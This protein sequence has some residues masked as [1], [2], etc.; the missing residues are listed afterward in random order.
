[1]KRILLLGAGKIGQTIRLFLDQL[2]DI[3]LVI[4]DLQQLPPPDCE[5]IKLESN[6][7]LA[8]LLSRKHIDAVIN[9]GPFYLSTK[10][11]IAAFSA[12]C[13]YFDLTE[14]IKASQHIKSLAEKAPAGQLFA[15][16]CGLA[17]GFISILCSHICSQF[18]TL[19]TVRL[20]VGAL[21]QYP[22]N[23]M[24]YNLTWSTDGLVNEY[25]NP[26]EVIE[27]GKLIHVPALDN[28]EEFS[29]E[30]IRYEAFNTSG[31]LGSLPQSLLNKVNQ[32]N[33]KTIRYPG[34]RDLMKFLLKDLKFEQQQRQKELVQLLDE[35]IPMTTQD[36]VL[37]MV[38]V[39]G[40]K[41]LANGELRYEKL[42]DVR[43][44]LHRT[45]Q[46]QD[47]SAIQ[48]TTAA[49]LCAIVELWLRGNFK[50]Q[51]FLLQEDVNYQDFIHT[52]FGKYLC[53]EGDHAS[54]A[55]S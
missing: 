8:A 33:Y 14:D 38:S 9:A 1:M 46:T 43:K 31:G 47:L 12:G 32:L 30:G 28:K 53:Q 25:C 55:G 19:D 37:I 15:P 36:M 13:S 17:P 23:Q 52:H 26:C 27:Q 3:E 2:N 44:I 34:H 39:A 40:Q 7:D 49:S 20:R 24:L 54:L 18:E 21:P 6:S 51:K 10:T 48:I 16:Q 11:A 50:K 35:N 41:R 5:F 4:A 42:T 29:L 45:L 22:D